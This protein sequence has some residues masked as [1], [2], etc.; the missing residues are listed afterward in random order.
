VTVASTPKVIQAPQT[1]PQTESKTETQTKTIVQTKIKPKGGE[2]QPMPP[3]TRDAIRSGKAPVPRGSVTWRQGVGWW[4]RWPPYGQQDRIFTR[5]KPRGAVMVRDARSAYDTIQTFSGIPP[6]KIP[7]FDMGIMDVF[8]DNP[9]GI[10]IRSNRD[11]I[12]FTRDPAMIRRPKNRSL[13]PRK[14]FRTRT[15]DL[16][17]GIVE[18]RTRHG[19]R[20]HLRLT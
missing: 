14:P 8:V 20:R 16:G 2:Y 19:R 3:E 17:V 13:S 6:G 4:T 1:Q 10:P 9:P 7:K 11:S 15:T 18:T 5:R 12:A